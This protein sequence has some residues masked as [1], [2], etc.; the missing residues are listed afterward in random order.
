MITSAPMSVALSARVNIAISG[1]M[2]RVEV[3]GGSGG[4]VWRVERSSDLLTWESLG[5]VEL[6]ANEGLG[7]GVLSDVPL[8]GGSSFFRAVR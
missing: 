2:L 8:E 6:E 1:G 3:V 7:S 5:T 4:E